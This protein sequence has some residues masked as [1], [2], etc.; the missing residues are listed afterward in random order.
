[1]NGDLI[2]MVAANRNN[3]SRAKILVTQT[4]EKKKQVKEEFVDRHCVVW[5]YST[6]D[7]TMVA[8]R[9]TKLP[10]RSSA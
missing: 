8:R 5:E 1:M 7:S 10:V 3:R 9:I 4:I 2:L 6:R